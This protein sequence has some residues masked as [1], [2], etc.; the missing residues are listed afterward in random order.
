MMIHPWL[1]GYA[2]MLF[3]DKPI[4]FCHLFWTRI[5]RSW[6]KPM[7]PMVFMLPVRCPNSTVFSQGLS[8]LV[9][10]TLLHGSPDSP[11]FFGHVMSTRAIRDWMD[12][13]KG[14]HGKTGNHRFSHEKIYWGFPVEFP[15]NQ[16][17]ERCAE[18]LGSSLLQLVP[19]SMAFVW[20]CSLSKKCRRIPAPEGPS[21]M[22]HSIKGTMCVIARCIVFRC[23]HR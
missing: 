1:Y 21:E 8:L 3:S 18:S 20:R 6:P 22:R 10:I 2:A 5:S 23:I 16:S 19:L 4:G 7:P 14:K 11:P 13:L 17:I 12:W 9:L 15:L